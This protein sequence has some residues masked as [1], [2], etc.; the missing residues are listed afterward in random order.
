MEPGWTYTLATDGFL[1]QAGGEHGFGFGNTRFADMLKTHA[2]RPLTEQVA[3]FT[4]A[5]ADYQGGQPQRDD[6]TLLSF[7]FE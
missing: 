3:A 4:Q 7:R 2:R 6:I 1:D 5:L